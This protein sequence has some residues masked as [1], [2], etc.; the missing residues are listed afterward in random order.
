MTID[1]SKVESTA[2]LSDDKDLPLGQYHLK[3]VKAT[4]ITSS[5]GTPGY[6]YEFVVQSGSHQ[7]RHQWDKWWTSPDA[8]GLLRTRAEAFGVTDLANFDPERDIV[9]REAIGIVREDTYEGKTRNKLKAYTVLP[10][11]SRDPLAS[12]P[13][14]GSSPVSDE[15][16][17]FAASII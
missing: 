16:I 11:S 7:G 6:E 1:L 4:K 3:A 2:P 14:G 15:D 12:A 9:G 8:L 17:P 5:K 13:V 10:S